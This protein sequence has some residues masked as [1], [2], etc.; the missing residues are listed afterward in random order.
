MRLRVADMQEERLRG[1]LP[2]EKR[3]SPF[4]EQI[5]GVVLVLGAQVAL[6]QEAR[7]V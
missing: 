4:S 3:K 7:I 5:R 2:V 6:A 1:R